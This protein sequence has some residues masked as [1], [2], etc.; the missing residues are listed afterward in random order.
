MWM[1]AC[2]LAFVFW[3][4]SGPNSAKAGSAT[5]RFALEG[6]NSSGGELHVVKCELNVT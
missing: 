2:E 1:R 3:A 4:R 5:L 6:S